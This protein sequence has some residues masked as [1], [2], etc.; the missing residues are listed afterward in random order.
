MLKSESLT[1]PVGRAIEDIETSIMHAGDYQFTGMVVELPSPAR[2][3]KGERV[4]ILTR[5][6]HGT[7]GESLVPVEELT[8]PEIERIFRPM[9]QRHAPRMPADVKEHQHLYAAM[10]DKLPFI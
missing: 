8:A 1:K 4:F 10:I 9:L 6:L 2:G 3:Q 5:R 7:V